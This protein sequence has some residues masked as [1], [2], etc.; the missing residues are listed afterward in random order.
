MKNKADEKLLAFF[1]SLKTIALV[2]SSVL[3]GLLVGVLYTL[4]FGE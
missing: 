4:I 1:N 2:I 3:V